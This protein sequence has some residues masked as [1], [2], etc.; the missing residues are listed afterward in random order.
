[1]PNIDPAR[2][3]AFNHTPFRG[4]QQFC[5]TFQQSLDVRLRDLHSPTHS[6]Y[7]ARQWMATIIATVAVQHPLSLPIQRS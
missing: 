3:R 7:A 6:A 4:R 2:M 1:M 5:R